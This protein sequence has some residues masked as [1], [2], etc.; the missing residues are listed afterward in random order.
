MYKVIFILSKARL[1][2]SLEKLQIRALKFITGLSKCMLVPPNL[3]G[4]GGGQGWLAR[5]DLS[6]PIEQ[7]VFIL[8]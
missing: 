7:S 1:T 5:P 8:E 2:K 3:G 4:G 6:D